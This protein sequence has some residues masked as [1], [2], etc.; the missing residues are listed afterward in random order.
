[1]SA[2]DSPLTARAAFLDDLGG[3]AFILDEEL[4]I[5]AGNGH[6]RELFRV[7]ASDLGARPTCEEICE[8]QHCGSKSCPIQKAGRLGK[9]ATAE[10][11]HNDRERG[12]L[13]LRVSATPLLEGKKRVGTLVTVLDVTEER[14]RQVRLQQLENNLNVITTPIVEIDTGFTVTYMNPAGAAVLGLTPEEAVGKKCYDLFKT[15]H[16]KTELCACARAMRTDA[17][18]TAQTIARPRDGLLIPIK[19]TGAPIKDAKGNIKGESMNGSEKVYSKRLVLRRVQKAD[20]LQL[21][22]WSSSD[23]AHGEYLSKESLSHAECLVRFANGYFWNQHARTFVIQLVEGLP[24]GTIRS[25]T[26]AGE[27]TVAVVAIKI[28]AVEHRG[29]GYGTEA[30]AAVI[31]YLF[32]IQQYDS[33]EMVTDI[34]NIAE[35]RCLIR[36]GFDH[37]R[38][39]SYDDQGTSRLGSLYRLDRSRYQALPI[40]KL[41]YE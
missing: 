40:Y 26:K 28:A 8:S 17:T 20:L 1:M 6:F 19:Y 23:T 5:A 4:R 41:G 9:T 22:E 34:D 2:T 16:C 27:H 31:K 18:V 29:K 12:A 3:P 30:Q 21:A 37:T 13:H 35:Q 36:L 15:P 39:M 32:S 38:S 14:G 7:S 25:W 24:I 11:I 10:E 33:V